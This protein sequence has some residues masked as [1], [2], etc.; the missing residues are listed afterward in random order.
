MKYVFVGLLML[1]ISSCNSSNKDIF[2]EGEIYIKLIDVHSLYG[3]PTNKL[4]EFKNSIVNV[5]S[6]S[7][8]GDEKKSKQ[9]FMFLIENNLF[10]KSHFKLKA[11]DGNIFNIYTT[12]SEF[13]TLKKELDILN[14]DKEIITVNFKG[15]KISEGY[16]NEPLYIADKIISVKKNK[17]VTDWSK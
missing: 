10:N 13:S 14:R 3:L 16:F 1:I 4:K 2:F 12:E 7:L 11:K 8:S 17:G 9:H 6:D 5:S 15:K